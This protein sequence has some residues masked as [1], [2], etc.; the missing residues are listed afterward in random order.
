LSNRVRSPNTRGGGGGGQS[1]GGGD[2]FTTLKSESSGGNLSQENEGKSN[3][4]LLPA[5]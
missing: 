5:K 2:I 1:G 3:L 4:N